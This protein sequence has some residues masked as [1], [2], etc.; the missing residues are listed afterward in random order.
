MDLFEPQTIIERAIA[1][2]LALIA[3]LSAAGL[4]FLVLYLVII[5]LRLKKREQISLEMVTFEIKTPKHNKN[6]RDNF[7]FF[8]FTF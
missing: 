6:L 7:S 5:F 8:L 3:A 2:I 1:F 4:T